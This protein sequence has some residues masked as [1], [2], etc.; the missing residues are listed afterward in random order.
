MGMRADVEQNRRRKPFTVTYRQ[1]ATRLEVPGNEMRKVMFGI[2]TK[3]EVDNMLC[4][5]L[6]PAIRTR[7]D[8]GA[9]TAL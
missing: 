6:R 5:S 7:R 9:D 3:A 1:A 8:C 4:F 2:I